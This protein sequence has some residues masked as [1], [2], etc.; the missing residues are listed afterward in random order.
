MSSQIV[1][2]V[3]LSIKPTL[4]LVMMVK[5]ENKRITVSLDSV[6]DIADCFIILDTGSEDNT[7]NIIREYCKTHNK[8]LHLIEQTF[9]HPFNFAKARNVVLDFADDKADYLLLLDCNDELRGGEDLRKFIDSYIGGSTAFHTCQE[10]WN[11]QSL[12]KYYNIRLVKS[13]HS[14]RYRGAIHEYIMSPEAEQQMEDVKNNP[15]AKRDPVVSRVFGF[16]LYQDRTQDDD[17]SFK[18]FAR[19]EEIFHHDYEEFVSSRDK[20]KNVKPDPRMLFYYGQTCMCLGKNEKAYKLYKERTEQEGFTEERYH[21]YYRCGETSKSLGHDWEESMTWYIKAYEYSTKVF[22]SPRA[23]P[24]YRL[25][26]YYRDKCWDLCF[27]YLRRCCEVVYPEN[28]ILFV[29]KRMYDYSRWNL[30][31]I[32]AYYAKQNEIGKISC[33]KA[34]ESE[35][36][37]I[38]RTNLLFYV[39]NEDEAKKLIKMVKE[40]VPI[41]PSSQQPQIEVE[42]TPKEILQDKM[43]SLKDKRKKK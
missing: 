7:I 40:K 5:N 27:M 28:A 29:D 10:W 31:G 33:L 24:L 39:P 4:G 20:D 16:S 21:A 35:D 42:K 30:M 8:P 9:P 41:P 22:D 26:E 23:E 15:E 13:K 11:G 17:K 43:K 32:V 6:R 19:D 25:A 12:D 3:P 2:N 14:W 18:R 37:E 38:D 36:H 34:I 1:K